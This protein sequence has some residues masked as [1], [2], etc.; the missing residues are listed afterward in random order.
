VTTRISLEIESPCG[1]MKTDLTTGEGREHDGAEVE[2]TRIIDT[3]G[4]AAVMAIGAYGIDH[5]DLIEAIRSAAGPTMTARPSTPPRRNPDGST[6][7]TVKTCCRACGRT[8]GDA[9]REELD[10]AIAG[11]PLPDLSDE[12]GCKGAR[13]P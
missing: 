1:N 10:D 7:I 5:Q 4:F 6:T 9:T 3:L 2:A 13:Q 11:L 12:C 8:L